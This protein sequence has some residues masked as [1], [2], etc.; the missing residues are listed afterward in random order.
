MNQVEV[1]IVETE[2]LKSLVKVLLYASMVGA[3][4]LGLFKSQTGSSSTKVDRTVMKIS[5]RLSQRSAD[6]LLLYR[7]R[8]GEAYGTPESLMPCPTSASLPDVT[9][10]GQT[11]GMLHA[12]YVP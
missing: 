3:P 11:A 7:T 8:C 12:L 5:S 1:N 6:T 10:L 9:E 2:S 4:E